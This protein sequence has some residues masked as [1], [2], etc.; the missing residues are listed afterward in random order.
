MSPDTGFFIPH[1]PAILLAAT[2]TS[3]SLPLLLLL[4]FGVAKLFANV[5][6]RFG[7]PGI[8]GEILAGVVLGPSVLNWVQPDH[9][10]HALAEMGVLFLLFRVGLEVKASDLMRVGGT[11]LLVACVGVALPFAAGWAIMYAAGGSNVE[12]IFVGAALTATSV[13]ITAQVLAS[14]GWLQ[15][16]ASQ[17]ILAAAVIDDILGLLILSLVSSVAEGHVNLEAL[18]TTGVIAFGFMILVASYGARTMQ[19]I[20]PRVERR[21]KVQEGQFTLAMVLL[22]A[23]ALLAVYAG[24]AA[25]VG[26]FL[27]GMALS[28]AV[29]PRVHDLTHGVT[30][31]LLPFFLAGIGLH[32][33]LSVFSDRP[34]LE[35]AVAVCVLAIFSK[36]IACGLGAF[37][38]GRGDMLR[39]GVGMIP[40]GEVGMVVAQIGLSLGVVEERVYAI[41]VLMAIVTTLVAPPLLKIAY[42]SSRPGIPEQ[43][44][45]LA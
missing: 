39:V 27:A 18:A 2:P 38:L 35:L 8:V 15:A 7:Q 23:L 17:V 19:Q 37:R 32:V 20:I 1:L 31:L 41:V 13:G 29:T 24:V 12:T 14:R 16:R 3:L 36:L 4:I 43:K 28:E 40:R 44:F 45:T 25:I 21:L 30:E 33:E 10:L 11:A 26:A 42:R 9:L 6:E 22:F 5:C 34:T